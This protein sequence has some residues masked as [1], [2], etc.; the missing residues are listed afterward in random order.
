[1]ALTIPKKIGENIDIWRTRAKHAKRFPYVFVVCTQPALHCN[2][3]SGY[4]VKCEDAKHVGS[5]ISGDTSCISTHCARVHKDEGTKLFTVEQVEKEKQQYFAEN[6]AKYTI[7]TY[8][9]ASNIEDSY[10]R[11]LCGQS[12]LSVEGLQASMFRI[13]AEVKET[14]RGCLYGQSIVLIADEGKAFKYGM[15]A[16]VAMTSTKVFLLA[17]TAPMNPLRTAV[18]VADEIRAVLA[19]FGIAMGQM[20]TFIT[21]LCPKIRK[22]VG[23]IG[24]RWGGCEN[25]LVQLAS[26]DADRIL[27]K[28]PVGEVI[29]KLTHVIHLIHDSTKTMGLLREIV[30]A[31]TGFGVA[32]PFKTTTQDGPARGGAFY[33]ASI[34]SGPSGNC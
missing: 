29:A 16:I 23:L 22:A 17:I 3:R 24:A 27:Q 6:F 33:Q 18:V 21:D 15:I 9:P 34:G 31:A 30:C 32:L 12:G 4:C 5:L 10:I 11:M 28:T 19:D 20:V 26:K 14:I 8:H 13:G 7:L 25:H 2:G 1:V